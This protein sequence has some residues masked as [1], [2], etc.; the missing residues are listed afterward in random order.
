[1]VE[2]FL[3]NKGMETLT[4]PQK[5]AYHCL[6]SIFLGKSLNNPQASTYLIPRRN[7]LTHLRLTSST[8][9]LLPELGR[10]S[11]C[12]SFCPPLFW[13]RLVQ[14]LILKYNFKNDMKYHFFVIQPDPSYWFLFE[15]K[16]VSVWMHRKDKVRV[17]HIFHLT[18][19]CSAI[20]S[21]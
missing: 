8:S 5:A 17:F 21:I 9:T 6:N 14:S 18:V 2:I 16:I 7:I 4:V 20:L 19:R 15:L 3:L 10:L 12:I 11:P 1:M 13:D